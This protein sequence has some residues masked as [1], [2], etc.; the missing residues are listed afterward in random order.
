MV[1]LR[2]MSF[3][4]I[5][6]C[7]S[8]AAMQY[9]SYILCKEGKGNCLAALQALQADQPVQK[10]TGIVTKNVYQSGM[11]IPKEHRHV[12]WIGRTVD[13]D[14]KWIIVTSD[15]VY[16][17]HSCNPNCQVMPDFE[18][19]TAKSAEKDEELTISYNSRADFP[20]DMHWKPEWNF[21]CLCK[22]HNCKK[23][24]DKFV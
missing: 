5:L 16:L 6:V 13:G 1:K 20:A 22:S 11:D 24:I 3:L 21:K 23:T 17:N 18:V 2:S 10:F 4:K 12:K 19:R 14:D 15:A 9:P 7:S 8:L